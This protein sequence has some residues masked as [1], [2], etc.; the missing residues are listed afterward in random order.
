MQMYV[1]VNNIQIRPRY[2]ER[3]MFTNSQEKHVFV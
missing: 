1:Y 3:G 2:G